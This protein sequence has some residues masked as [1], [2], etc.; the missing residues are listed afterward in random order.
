M[1]EEIYY[2]GTNLKFAITITAEGFLMDDDNYVCTLCCGSKRVEVKKDDIV[3]G[4]KGQ[5]Y[6]LIDT[7]QFPSG[8]LRWVVTASVPDSDYVEGYRNEVEAKDLCI[9]KHPW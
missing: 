7:K 6:M 4:E 2:I 3:E 8:T 1:E 9:L 5:K